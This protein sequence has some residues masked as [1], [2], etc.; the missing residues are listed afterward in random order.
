MEVTY[1]TKLENLLQVNASEPRIVIPEEKT[2]YTLETRIKV[3]EEEI[4]ALES[5]FME[6]TLEFMTTTN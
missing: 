1:N 3:L 6:A 4:Y 2:Q 5:E